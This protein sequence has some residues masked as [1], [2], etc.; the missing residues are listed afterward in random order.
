M[1]RVED[2]SGARYTAHKEQPRKFVPIAPVGTN[3]T[4][5]KVDINELKKAQSSKPS[6][7]TKPASDFI[8]P[9]SLIYD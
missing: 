2:S 9:I 6:T 7:A 4:P 1:K 8:Y 5:T 3:Y